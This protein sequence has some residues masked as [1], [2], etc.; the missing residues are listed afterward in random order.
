MSF[1]SVLYFSVF[2]KTPCSYG[3]EGRLPRYSLRSF[4]A[5]SDCFHGHL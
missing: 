3:E 5:M 1:A 2:R 4:L